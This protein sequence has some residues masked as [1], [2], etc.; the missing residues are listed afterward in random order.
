MLMQKYE[1]G[2]YT[3]KR[4][5]TRYRISWRWRHSAHVEDSN[6]GMDGGQ[7][8]NDQGEVLAAGIASVDIAWHPL[9]ER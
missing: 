3:A 1:K 4:C 2:L 8:G 5:P 7:S 6:C 9:P